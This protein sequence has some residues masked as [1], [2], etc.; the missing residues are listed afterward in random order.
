MS[1][2]KI[3]ITEAFA[4]ELREFRI[5]HPVNGSV[6]SG[7]ALADAIGKSRCWI[8][9]LESPNRNGKK[10]VKTTELYLIFEKLLGKDAYK[11]D[12]YLNFINRHGNG[13]FSNFC[14][15]QNHRAFSQISPAVFAA[16][17]Y[18]TEVIQ[19]L[20]RFKEIFVQ[21]ITAAENDE[22]RFI[23]LRAL[24]ML[25]HNLQSIPDMTVV[26]N[27]LPIYVCENRDAFRQETTKKLLAI[28]DECIDHAAMTPALYDIFSAPVIKNALNMGINRAE[29]AL[30]ILKAMLND[31]D[32]VGQLRSAYNEHVHEIRLICESVYIAEGL[33]SPIDDA[34][35]IDTPLICDHL[36]AMDALKKSLSQHLEKVLPISEEYTEQLERNIAEAQ[37][38]DYQAHRFDGMEQ[39][40]S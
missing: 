33:V 10:F 1:V 36:K 37:D 14:D 12:E 18:E 4:K 27:T 7:I 34:V 3:K 30:N 5:S 23:I 13:T 8:S 24:N 25:V 6:M 39:T 35:Q 29:Q 19:S 31:N 11:S 26:L 16:V 22:K 2:D 28:M 40:E 17:D 15:W 21:Y 32:A 38:I 9:Q 20:N